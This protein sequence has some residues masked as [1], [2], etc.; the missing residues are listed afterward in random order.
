MRVGAEMGFDRASANDAANTLSLAIDQLEDAGL[1]YLAAH[2]RD[3]MDRL[4]AVLEGDSPMPA[5]EE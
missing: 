2:A 5:D 1:S 4:E 3:L